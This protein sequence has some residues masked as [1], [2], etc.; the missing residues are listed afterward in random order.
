MR[1]QGDLFYFIF[2]FGSNKCGKKKI[3][4]IKCTG[5]TSAGAQLLQ[6]ASANSASWMRELQCD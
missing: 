3:A 2:F 6:P 5:C 4:S 1:D